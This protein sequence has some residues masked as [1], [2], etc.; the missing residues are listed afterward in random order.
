V[1]YLVVGGPSIV[2]E[3]FTKEG[4]CKLLGEMYQEMID[5][6]AKFQCN[7]VAAKRDVLPHRS[8]R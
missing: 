7:K 6:R 1:I 8:D 4:D 3:G 2:I 5:S